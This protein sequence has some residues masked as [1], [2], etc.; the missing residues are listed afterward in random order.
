MREQSA[1]SSSSSTGTVEGGTSGAAGRSSRTAGLSGGAPAANVGG[2]LGEPAAAPSGAAGGGGAGAGGSAAAGGTDDPFGLHLASSG[3]AAGRTATLGAPAAALAGAAA[4]DGAT[5]AGA[6]GEALGVPGVPVI[7]GPATQSLLG[8]LG[9]RG[10]AAGGR[11]FVA[12]R[13]PHV[14]AH[15]LAHVAQG[16]AMAAT[17]GGEAAADAAADAA[18]RGATGD[19]AGEDVA[20][21]EEMTGL[22][23]GGGGGGGGGGGA[24]AVSEAGGGAGGADEV[25]AYG[26]RIAGSSVRLRSAPDG[27]S[28][29]NVIAMLAA[30]TTV[31]VTDDASQRDWVQV[32][33]GAQSGWVHR[34]F[35]TRADAAAAQPAQPVTPATPVASNGTP[36]QQAAAQQQGTAP[37]PAAAQSRAA[38]TAAGARPQVPIDQAPISGSFLGTSISAHP[39]LVWRLARAEAHLESQFN[40]SGAALRRR[41]QVSPGY[42]VHRNRDAYHHFALAIDINYSTNPY[43]GAQGGSNRPADRE[44]LAAIWRACLLTGS[45]E[46]LSPSTSWARHS[47]AGSTA[48][49]Y[50]SFQQSNRALE[51]YLGARGNAAQ[52]QQWIAAGNLQ[53]QVAPPSEVPAAMLS[54]ERLRAADAAAWAQQIEADFTATH[55]A[56]A[57]GSNWWMTGGGQRSALGFM[58]LDRDLVIALRDIGGLAWGASD[59]GAGANGDFM[60]FDC[61]RD[62]GREQL[63][64]AMAAPAAP[65]AQQAGP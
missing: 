1:S 57:R 32:Q 7:G 16:G 40:L 14:L 64:T 51:Q 4:L 25:A 60:H 56:R 13:D 39:T 20:V 46:A 2:L 47:G 53:R 49:L 8:E 26:G 65:A 42:S 58:N 63:R 36:Q 55:G 34:T 61:R 29:D 62:Y 37:Q 17:A 5:S 10:A 28:T 3:G 21:P 50:D 54:A 18:T 12:D 19:A 52:I 27:S 15:E 24:A 59:F 30:G 9:I 11:A 38:R 35:V 22:P 45:G 44:A 41:L 6:M 31:E 33:V 23:A 48:A 43:V